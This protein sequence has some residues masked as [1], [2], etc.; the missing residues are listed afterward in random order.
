[1][2][3]RRAG[4][5]E[6]REAVHSN[7]HTIGS[8]HAGCGGRAIGADAACTDGARLA[9]A[10][11]ICCHKSGAVGR[12]REVALELLFGCGVS[13]LGARLSI[14]GTDHQAFDAST[15][16]Q[17]HAFLRAFDNEKAFAQ[18]GGGPSSSSSTERRE[19]R[20]EKRSRSPC[21]SGRFG[22]NRRPPRRNRKSPFRAPTA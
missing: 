20:R 3:E 10:R 2:A 11:A 15:A 8:V 9:S 21:P 22:C 6:A 13:V 5:A 1:M 18:V 4:G 12:G 14:H 16:A 17:L 19:E 7:P